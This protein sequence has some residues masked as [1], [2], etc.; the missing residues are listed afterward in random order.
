MDPTQAHSWGFFDVSSSSFDVSG[1]ES[2]YRQAVSPFIPKVVPCGSDIGS[3]TT[4]AAARWFLPAGCR[5]HVPSGDH[6]SH[7]HALLGRLKPDEKPEHVLMMNIGTSAQLSLLLPKST[8]TPQ[9]L[10]A[11]TKKGSPYE[12]RPCFNPKY[13]LLTC[14]SLNGGNALAHLV[15]SVRQWCESLGATMPGQD[16]MYSSLL[17]MAEQKAATDLKFNPVFHGERHEP[18]KRAS[19]QN[20]SVDNFSLGDLVASLCSGLIAN[21]RS[22]LPQDTLRSVHRVIGSGNALTRNVLLQ[23]IIEEQLGVRLS[24]EVD[25]EAASGIMQPMTL[26]TL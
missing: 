7:V 23:R 4:E 1:M 9:A 24:I 15:Q 26:S 20:I 17:G 12:Y 13:L 22:M 16:E 5:V 3:V 21:L 2:A 11:A 14:A 10:S 6:Q 19:V 18:Q 8:V 25:A